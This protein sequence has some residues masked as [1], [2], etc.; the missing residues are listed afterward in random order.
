LREG[1]KGHGLEIDVQIIAPDGQQMWLDVTMLHET[2][3]TYAKKQL[4]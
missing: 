4:E 2:C 3:K 1:P